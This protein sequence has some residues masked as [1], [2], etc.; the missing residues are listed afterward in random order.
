MER[1][2]WAIVGTGYIANQFAQGLML[3]KD[4]QAVA[5]VSRN[6][7]KAKEYA[8]LYHVEASYVDYHRMLAEAKPDIVYVA[9]PN[10]CHVDYIIPALQAGVHVLSEK[11][12]ADNSAQLKLILDKAREKGLFVMEG[13]WT[14]S[15]PAVRQVRQWIKEG[16]IGKPLAVHAHFDIQ[17]EYDHWQVWKAGI[18]HTAGALRDVGIYALAMAYFVFP[19]EPVKV[20]SNMVKN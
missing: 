5:V 20:Y 19:E 1:I 4:A 7:K 18:A 16:K 9:V 13:M 8:D 14:R 10:D 12:M 2:R 17:P 3:V 6:A 15:F 11:P